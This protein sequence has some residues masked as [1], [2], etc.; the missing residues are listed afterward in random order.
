M[1]DAAQ[2]YFDLRQSTRAYQNPYE[3]GGIGVGG[4]TQSARY[5]RQ[6]V[7]SSFL[8]A[9]SGTNTWSRSSSIG[10]TD[11]YDFGGG[12]SIVSGKR[13]PVARQ[14]GPQ[15]TGMAGP[16]AT[17]SGVRGEFGRD[18]VDKKAYASAE[19]G[20]LV[21][22]IFRAGTAG[23][24]LGPEVAGDVVGAVRSRGDGGNDVSSRIRREVRKA[25]NATPVDVNQ[26]MQERAAA[27]QAGINE[28]RDL[29]TF[30]PRGSADEAGERPRLGIQEANLMTTPNIPRR[31]DAVPEG[32][33]MNAPTGDG[34]DIM[35][36]RRSP[37]NNPWSGL[38]GRMAEEL[39]RRGETVTPAPETRAQK[40]RPTL[41][42]RGTIAKS[43]EGAS[44]SGYNPSASA[45]K[46]QQ[47]IHD[48]STG[49]EYPNQPPNTR[50]QN[51]RKK[52]K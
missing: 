48:A 31:F 43:I 27:R 40:R 23:M 28:Q 3:S 30:G 7:G 16:E 1:S 51:R 42:L 25:Q 49:M 41:D 37:V 33:D 22:G 38:Q 39:A 26:A 10:G 24:G 52:P 9:P 32:Y 20:N 36:L 34:R 18:P 13:A 17:T 8:S 29:E 4:L 19:F 46:V 50:V 2:N 44:D 21:R 11:D 14:E 12:S 35:N 6:Q 5:N 47:E 45:D 15:R